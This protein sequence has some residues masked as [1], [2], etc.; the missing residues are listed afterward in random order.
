MPGRG[1]GMKTTETN[2]A[3]TPETA[4]HVSHA[5]VTPNPRAYIFVWRQTCSLHV[6]TATALN[7]RCRGRSMRR[8]DTLACNCA[9]PDW[10]LLH[11]AHTHYT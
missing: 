1:G 10:T 6:I 5:N 4:D 3:T 9:I 11:K 7:Q 2:R 8:E